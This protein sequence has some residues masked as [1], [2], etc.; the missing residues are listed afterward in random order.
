MLLM[1]VNSH[2]T[3]WIEGLRMK[4]A[5]ASATIEALRTVF[6]RFSLPETIVS[7]NSP[8][9]MGEGFGMF[10]WLNIVHLHTV[11]YHPQSKWVGS[12]LCVQ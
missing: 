9:F 12:V 4:N 11:P 1:V 2:T 7:D 6:S 10:L 8:Q 3:K 5:N